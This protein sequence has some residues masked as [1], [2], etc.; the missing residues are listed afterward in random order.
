MRKSDCLLPSEIQKLNI[1]LENDYKS[2]MFHERRCCKFMIHNFICAYRL[3]IP[4]IFWQN[5]VP[6]G[7]IDEPM[8]HL[9]WC[10]AQRPPSNRKE[11][12]SNTMQP[13]SFKYAKQGAE[14]YKIIYYLP[15]DKPEAEDDSVGGPLLLCL[16]TFYLDNQISP[17]EVLLRPHNLL[18]STAAL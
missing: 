7:S 11:V 9:T 1:I 15:I 16:L 6:R 8:P 18:A 2:I 5:L 14:I 17:P 13:S 10:H 4:C 12:V 3:F